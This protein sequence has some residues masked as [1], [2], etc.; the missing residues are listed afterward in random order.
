MPAGLADR[1]RLQSRNSASSPERE[2]S[3][4]PCPIGHLRTE[5]RGSGRP[6]WPKG[7]EVISYG[8][9]NALNAQVKDGSETMTSVAQILRGKG[10]QVWSVSPSTL[11]YQALKL[12]AEKDVG[13]LLVLEGDELKGIFSERDYARKVILAGKSSREIAV[14][15]IM[16]SE[17]ITVAPQKTVE[18]C[19]ALMTDNRVRHLP[20]VEGGRV[21]GV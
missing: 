17:V 13:A 20:V 18:E 9:V 5:S 1:A 8:P 14:K 7:A 6:C 10:H 21:V 2:V 16:S 3:K 11:V 19:M 12:M 15:E 4:E